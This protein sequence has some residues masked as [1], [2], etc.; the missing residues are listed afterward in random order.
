MLISGADVE[1]GSQFR[2]YLQ[3]YRVETSPDG[4]HWATAAESSTALPPL[5]S[6]RIDSQAVVQRIRFSPTE[7]RFLRLGPLRPSPPLG[8]LAPDAGFTRWGVA[9]LNLRGGV[10]RG[11]PSRPPHQR[12]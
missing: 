12:G 3:N 1:L 5:Q 10:R 9:E 7:A 4:V 11:R 6:Y 2:L 8:V